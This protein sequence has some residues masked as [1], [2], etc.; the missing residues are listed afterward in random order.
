MGC[1]WILF[2]LIIIGLRGHPRTSWFCLELVICRFPERWLIVVVQVG[3]VVVILIFIVLERIPFFEILFFVALSFCD[4][5]VMISQ[6]VLNW[7][8]SWLASL[9]KAWICEEGVFESSRGCEPSL[10]V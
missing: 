2:C 9:L 3:V 8:I 7:Q 5:L 6:Q 10:R 4:K 1:C